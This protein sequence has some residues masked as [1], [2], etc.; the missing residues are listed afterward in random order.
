MEN[1][2][3]KIK[4]AMLWLFTG[5][6]YVAYF[7]LMLIA[8]GAIEELLAGEIPE[9]QNPVIILT[10]A[11]IL[12]FLFIMPF[13]SLT[14]KDSINRWVNLIIGIIYAVLE[15][16]ALID[17]FSHTPYAHLVIMT[18]SKIVATALIV[19]YAWKWP[20]E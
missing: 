10:M 18:C 12:L 11:L 9:L 13:L 5:M 20:K 6:T 3:L 19:R 17:I 7:L 4:I 1:L 15:F 8:P 2:A 14:L 16:G